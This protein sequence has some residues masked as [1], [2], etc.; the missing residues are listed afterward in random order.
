M[1]VGAPGTGAEG[2]RYAAPEADARGA[3]PPPPVA[4]EP[5]LPFMFRQLGWS[6]LAVLA[7][8]AG[9]GPVRAQEACAPVRTAL[10]LSGGGARGLAHIGVL[11]TLDSLGVRPDLIVGTSM[12]A[13]VGA[14]YASGYSG[15][16][17]DSL[18]RT[19]P[20]ASLFRNYDPQAPQV[21]GALEPLVV[22]ADGPGGFAVQG[23]SVREAEA[24][25]LLGAAMLRGN[26]LARGDFDRLPIPFRAVATDLDDRTAV[27]L[28][29][30]DLAQAVRASIAI[31]LVFTPERIGARQL[32]D[33][34][35]SANI[36]VAIARAEGAERVIVSDVTERRRDSLDFASPLRVADRL[37]DF[38][39]DQPLDSLRAGDV[40]IR[41]AIE[42]FAS[43]DFTPAVQAELVQRGRTAAD[44]TLAGACGSGARGPGPTARP[45]RF[46]G[47]VELADARPG[48]ELL[49][50]RALGLGPGEALDAAALLRAVRRTEQLERYRAVWLG[51]T[52]TGDSVDFTLQVRRAPER[53]AALGVAYDADLG[54]RLW[55]G[56]VDQQ[57]LGLPLETSGALLV[58]ELRRE[59]R[60]AL[61]GGVGALGTRR[62]R[63][64]LRL[65]VATESVRRFDA[66]GEE[67]PDL[68]TREAVGFA[69]VERAGA[70][71]WTLA[72][73]GEVRVWHEPG[74]P[75]LAAAGL[76]ARVEGYGGRGERLAGLSA[77]G[78]SRYR[79]VTADATITARVGRLLVRP[80]ARLGWGDDLPAQLTIPL[81]G[82]D[83][84]PGL[85]LG[86]LRGDREVMTMLLLAHPVAGPLNGIVE[87]AAGRSAAGGPLLEGRWRSGIRVGLGADTPLGPVRVAY[88]F[89]SG[90]RRAAFVRIGRWF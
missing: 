29:G 39:F 41:P 16:A 33:G 14:M 10:V 74:R 25:A 65:G 68:D 90:G 35:L 67:L 12:G 37:V 46:V 69:G 85:H 52:G 60:V 87:L 84:F 57:P 44:T 31:P 34:G 42:G 21:F 26:L 47:G 20:V 43:L 73:G 28:D 24:N 51:P 27:V 40:R 13:I 7:T 32:A 45:P 18:A 9:A 82:D 19:L 53:Q 89:S 30:G 49:L 80:G 61:R 4:A 2:H 36:P 78:T 66:G 3:A 8:V 17:I 5:Y 63:P 6:L 59:L 71:G 77:V 56:V 62:L 76:A 55:V 83:G 23:A 15:R 72:A 58:G 38:L 70:R 11:R 81:G 22:W 86:E 64:A 79:R 48:E 88:G 1:P 54:G 75:D 50:A